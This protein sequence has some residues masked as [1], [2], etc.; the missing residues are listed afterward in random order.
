MNLLN[1]RG[2]THQP[3]REQ[4]RERPTNVTHDLRSSEAGQSEDRK[5]YRP[6]IHFRLTL[7]M[8]HDRWGREPCLLRIVLLALLRFWLRIE[9][10]TVRATNEINALLFQQ[11]DEFVLSL[12]K[13]RS[14]KP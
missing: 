12:G 3:R 8:G 4:Q 5:N 7:K 9:E 13:G 11:C 10:D 1:G 2:G 14:R 6:A